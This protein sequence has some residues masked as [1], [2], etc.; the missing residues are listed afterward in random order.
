MSATTPPYIPDAITPRCPHCG[1]TVYVQAE[2]YEID[3][4]LLN[5]KTEKRAQYRVRTHL[6]ETAPA[7]ISAC[8][9]RWLRESLP[10]FMSPQEA[11]A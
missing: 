7:V 2:D 3:F 5:G 11:A 8:V 10:R 6:V 1:E 9:C 4:K